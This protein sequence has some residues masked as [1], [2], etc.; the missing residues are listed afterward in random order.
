MAS[1]WHT[2]RGPFSNG[3][4][5][6]FLDRFSNVLGFRNEYFRNFRKL[7]FKCKTLQK[8]LD[9]GKIRSNSES[10]HT[11]VVLHHRICPAHSVRATRRGQWQMISCCCV[12]RIMMNKKFRSTTYVRDSHLSLSSFK[13][14]LRHSFHCRCS[15]RS[16]NSLSL[17]WFSSARIGSSQRAQHPAYFGAVCEKGFPTKWRCW[18]TRAS[19]SF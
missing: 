1:F 19:R 8:Q 3:K 4:D 13:K 12:H 7:C 2:L 6:N 9:V 14:M 17:C 18:S 11:G 15:G 10:K 16:L 5:Q